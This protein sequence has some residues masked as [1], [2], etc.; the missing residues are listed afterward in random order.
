MKLD[1]A[2]KDLSLLLAQ[3]VSTDNSTIHSVAFDT[4]Q[5]FS[6]EG[7][8]FFALEG[9]FRNGQEFINEAYSKGV[10][11]FVVTAAGATEYFSDA[12]E[13]VVEDA[14]SALQLLAKHHRNR[15]KC[16]IIAITG[17]NGK[18]T[19]KEWLGHILSKKF[20]VVRSPKSY[21]S[22]LGVALSLLE[23]T[24]STE[25][26]I[27]EVGIAGHGEM[28]EM[29]KIIRP[30]H[31]IL[32]H[33]G[34]AHQEL[35]A[36]RTEHL[37]EKIALFKNLDSF[38]CPEKISIELPMNARVVDSSQFSALLDNFAFDDAINRQNVRLAIDMAIQF[39]MNEGTISEAVQELSAL[40]LRLETY[41]GINGN[42]II[43]DTY[44]LDLDSLRHSLAY[45]LANSSGKQ[46]VVIIGLE[47]KDEIRENEIR[48][49]I[50]EFSPSHY[51]FHYLD[52]P[53]KY[54]FEN[55]NILIKGTRL[56]R[57]ELVAREFKQQNHQTYLEF[58]LKA[59]RHNIN[60]YK[61]LL[62][63][64][65]KLLCMVKASSYGSDAQR[66]GNF[67]EK[68]G[69][70]YL[71]VAYPDEGIELRQKGIQLPI[72]VMNCEESSFAQCI[73]F[74]LEPAI[75]SI[76]QMDAF[77]KELINRSV[78][79]YSVHIKIETGM[80]RLG[81][82][83][84]ELTSIIDLIKAQP[85][86]SV[87]SVYSHLIE[88]DVQDSSV[89]L[90][91]ISEFDRLSTKFNSEFAYPIM[92]HLSN[93]EGI[94]NYPEAQ[95]DMV[96]LGIGMYGVSSNKHLRSSIS[97]ISSI[98]QVKK[99]RKGSSVGYGRVFVADRDLRIAVIPVGYADGFRRSLGK[100]M[101]GVYIK[102]QYCPVVGNVCMDML[103]VDLKDL[104]V[105]EGDAVEIIGKHQSILDLA[106]KCDTIPYEIMTSFS[107]RVHRV[108]V[109]Q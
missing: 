3:T 19:V 20:N 94:Q 28:G 42:T 38:S 34:T 40:A 17:S 102:D 65:T 91:Q 59:I 103:M 60:Y 101:G 1:Y 29:E 15:F 45:Q 30:T 56:S 6:G 72:L 108:Y 92:R 27:I 69:V 98:S 25:A 16:P 52:N 58:D 55:A 106:T 10:R 93:S 109:D 107:K 5:I 50:A 35:F 61:S 83:E 84:D 36:S 39:G 26:A 47:S 86:I 22:K 8:L 9:V 18:T 77:I 4:R 31:G 96:R 41:D 48:A 7:V 13:I 70:D 81:I 76:R 14:L 23:L 46:R 11:H 97:W 104:S 100:G 24:S 82:A 43:N 68:M 89:T 44:S 21:N 90:F 75:F 67:L 79:N 37:A 53:I 95:F 32:T 105:R 51:Y 99:I 73:E 12:H 80:N 64:T 63:D 33:F 74:N 2:Y 62:S 57:M 88:S 78:L 49:I 71:G 54:E 85:E 87:R 66:M